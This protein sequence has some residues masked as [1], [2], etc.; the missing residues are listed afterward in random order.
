MGH[1]QNLRA[2]LGSSAWVPLEVAAQL[3]QHLTVLQGWANAHEPLDPAVALLINIEMADIEHLLD[4]GEACNLLV[5]AARWPA[6]VRDVEL[7]TEWL[8]ARR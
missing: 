2:F 5:S 1:R 7:L 4:L 6:A 3:T 8:T